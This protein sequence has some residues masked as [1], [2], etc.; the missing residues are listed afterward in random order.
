MI[1][2]RNH[3][4]CERNPH[5]RARYIKAVV[6]AKNGFVRFVR[7]A[8]DLL[9]QSERLLRVKL[10]S[11]QGGTSMS[12]LGCPPDIQSSALAIIGAGYVFVKILDNR[13]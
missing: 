4:L 1:S 9:G 6:E 2:Q 7:I 12:A 3:F 11:P 5:L 10:R 13:L 8:A